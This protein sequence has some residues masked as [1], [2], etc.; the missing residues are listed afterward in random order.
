VSLLL[1]VVAEISIIAC[2]VQGIIATAIAL[3]ILF[4]FPL[5]LGALFTCIDLVTF[6]LIDFAE[7]D[8]HQIEWLFVTLVAM[9]AVCFFWN[10]SVN[11]PNASRQTLPLLPHSPLLHNPSHSPPPIHLLSQLSCSVPSSPR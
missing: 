9:M 7:V 1:W 6:M 3:Q 10:F 8:S 4:G 5:W 11:P 2:D